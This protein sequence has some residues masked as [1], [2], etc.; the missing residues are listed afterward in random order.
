SG[1]DIS[2]ALVN[3]ATDVQ[4]NPALPPTRDQV[5]TSIV[6]PNAITGHTYSVYYSAS[7]AW[8]LR[9]DVTGTTLISNQTE[10]TATPE[11]A[12]VDG[13]VV[14]L[15]GDSVTATDVLGPVYICPARP[16]GS[17]IQPVDG[18]L[19]AFGGGADVA[20]NFFAGIDPSVSP[21]A[22]R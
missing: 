17:V 4:A 8:N 3:C 10:R 13:M 6:D 11:F 18:G 9:D 22:F 20:W 14:T 2:S 19:S 15:Q 21:G 5:V 12:P 7:G 16:G 1:T